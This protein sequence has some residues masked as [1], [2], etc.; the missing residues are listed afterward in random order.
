MPAIR[1]GALIG[2]AVALLAAPQSG[3]QTRHQ[4]RETAGDAL[5]GIRESID[6]LRRKLEEV[7]RAV[8]RRVPEPGAGEAAP[9]PACTD[10]G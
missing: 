4:L 3:L 1:L 7:R 8:R 5:D 9:D 10:A 6:E 2:A